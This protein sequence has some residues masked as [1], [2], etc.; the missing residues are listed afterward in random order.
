MTMRS[1]ADLRRLVRERLKALTADELQAAGDAIASSVWKVPGLGSARSLLLYASLPCEV[2]TDAIATEARR[3]GISVVYP[4]CLAESRE[5]TLHAVRD[6][7]DLLEGG[8]YGIREPA[9]HCPL[10]RP[11][12]IDVAFIP[13][14]AWDRAGNRL[15]RGAGYYDRL[16]ADPGWRALRCGLF[17]SAQEVELVPADEWDVPLDLVVTEKGVLELPAA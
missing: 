6:A 17:Y 3:R 4:R 10:T 16:L 9:D 5:M 11:E 14:L 2:P 12:E 7:D 15:G 8:R 13:G 1:K